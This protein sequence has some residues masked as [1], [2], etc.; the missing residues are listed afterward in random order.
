MSNEHKRYH[1][2]YDSDAVWMECEES[3][4]RK[5]RGKVKQTKIKNQKSNKKQPKQPKQTTS[6][7]KKKNL[8]VEGKLKIHFCIEDSCWLCHLQA[9]HEQQMQRCDFHHTQYLEPED[10]HKHH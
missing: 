5:E 1:H 6:N 4:K 9:I 7:Q 8:H 2:I 3:W 10:K